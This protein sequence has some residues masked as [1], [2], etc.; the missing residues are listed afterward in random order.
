M[1]FV[2]SFNTKNDDECDLK[3]MRVKVIMFNAQIG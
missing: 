1:F 2:I 3:Q